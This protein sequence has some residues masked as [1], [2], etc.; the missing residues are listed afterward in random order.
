MRS[1]KY[2][3]CLLAAVWLCSAPIIYSEFLQTG[4]Y[5]PAWYS[6][7]QYGSAP[8]WFRDAK[9]GV[10]ANWDPCR[11]DQG[12]MQWN[13]D[14]LMALYQRTGANYFLATGS[15]EPHIT[16]NTRKDRK[17]N[18]AVL[19]RWEQAARS[20]GLRFG[21]SIHRPVSGNEEQP[22]P[23]SPRRTMDMLRRHQPDV[24]FL[25]DT[26]T[27]PWLACDYDL[28]AIANFYNQRYEKTR[29]LNDALVL[30]GGLTQEQMQC[31]VWN[32][33]QQPPAT[34]QAKPWQYCL[35]LGSWINSR[36]PYGYHGNRP[37]VAVVQT[38]VDVISKNGNLLLLMSLNDNGT[39]S[40]KDRI[41]LDEMALWIRVNG[42]GVFGTRPWQFFGEGPTTEN[43]CTIPTSKDIRFVQKSEDETVYAHVMAWPEDGQVVVKSL[44][45]RNNL[46]RGTVTR[47]QLLGYPHDLI[48]RQERKGLV[49]QL[50]GIRPN[51]I[52]PT[53]KI[54]TMY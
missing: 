37:A 38:L 45:T 25:E 44:G 22:S 17:R 10:W 11:Q 39:I 15:Q 51:P 14:S 35:S 20:Y 27:T 7:S 36:S 40:R 13:P 21:F 2:P 26:Q 50:P 28:R 5:Q 54:E 9:L 23:Y 19:T 48:Y 16:Y 49:V 46:A 34:K 52:S 42:E 8:E 53:L 43:E 29:E 32:T 1:L 4:P 41:T 3:L 31:M 33:D 12:N 24:V 6:L 30:A 47:V 18:K